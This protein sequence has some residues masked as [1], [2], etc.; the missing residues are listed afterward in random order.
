MVKLKIRKQAENFENAV[1]L[2][3]VSN[4]VD[5]SKMIIYSTF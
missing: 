2:E 1:L 5:Q 4:I 3:D